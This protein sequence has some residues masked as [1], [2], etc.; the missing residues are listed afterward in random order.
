MTRL[1]SAIAL[2]ALCSLLACR[3]SQPEARPTPA[4]PQPLRAPQQPHA[5]ATQPAPTAPPATLDA[6]GAHGC[7]GWA[8]ATQTVACVEGE[9]GLGAEERTWSLTLRSGAS[10]E[11]VSLAPSMAFP[12]S[13]AVTEDPLPERAVREAQLRLTRGGFTA[14]A[15]LAKS[16]A[17]G[18][19]E[20]VGDVKV[21]Y[22]REQRDRAGENQAPQYRERVT[23][24]G[25]GVPT[26]IDV[27]DDERIASGEDGSE[28][29]AYAVAPTLVV[30][31]RR[32]QVSDEGINVLRAQSWVC[33]IVARRCQ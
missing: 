20:N 7:V 9:W 32:V 31:H 22:T 19:I 8:A 2:G 21:H 33:D 12:S 4:Q 29:T 3:R 18:A 17:P 30:V 5:A 1:R 27:F 26:P 28:L 10:V 14:L 23:I 25:G 24:T 13:S 16:I 15:S 11:R 6:Q